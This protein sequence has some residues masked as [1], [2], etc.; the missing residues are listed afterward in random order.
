ME[1][2]QMK[3]LWKNQS[4]NVQHLL[5]NEEVMTMIN[6]S[7]NSP[8]AKMKRN[9]RKELIFVVVSFSMAAFIFLIG[10]DGKMI[11]FSAVYVFL[12]LVYFLYFFFKN[13]LLSSMQCVVC[14]VKSNL[15]MQ[16]SSLEKYIKYNLI[17]STL[18]VPVIF[19][20]G[21][22][23]LYLDYHADSF[24]AIIFYSVAYPVW[25]TTVVWVGISIVLTVP[26]YFLNRKYLHWLYGKHIS[27]IRKILSEM[28]EDQS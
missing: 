16:V 6:H 22:F 26:S 10:F 17:I 27:R 7:S 18:I 2:D 9:L 23:I 4:L 1:L 15:S 12:M 28:D 5:S 19:M 20:L 13:R 11:A 14:E 21:A 24:K 8:V 3:D 25:V